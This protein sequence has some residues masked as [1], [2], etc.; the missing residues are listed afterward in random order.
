MSFGRKLSIRSDYFFAEFR[1]QDTSCFA[2]VA[3]GLVLRNSKS[4]PL[5]LLFFAAAKERGAPTALKAAK[6]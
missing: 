3:N 1:T 4:S 6:L 2:R 5:Y